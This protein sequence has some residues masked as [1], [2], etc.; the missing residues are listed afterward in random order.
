MDRREFIAK[1]GLATTWA[2]ISIHIS[3]C[4]SDGPTGLANAGG[5]G[6]VSG[7]VTGGGHGHD[8]AVITAAELQDG[9]MLTLTLTGSGHTHSVE[10]SAAQVT[11]IA[12]GDP[13]VVASS[14]DGGH[15]HTV[16]FN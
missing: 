3:G 7:V 6:D 15:A 16:S 11:A 13:V 9:G 5:D 2:L 12:D 1:A 14:S 4:S 10:L 8:G